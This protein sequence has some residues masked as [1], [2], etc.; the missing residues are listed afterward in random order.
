MKKQHEKQLEF[1]GMGSKTTH[2]SGDFEDGL[3]SLVQQRD[4]PSK[5]ICQKNNNSFGRPR[6]KKQSWHICDQDLFHLAE[7]RMKMHVNAP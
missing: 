2:R 5:N 4:N 7:I 1:L 3:L 6:C